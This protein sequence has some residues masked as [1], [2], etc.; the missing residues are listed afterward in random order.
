MNSEET[1]DPAIAEAMGC[2]DALSWLK[3]QNYSR[4]ILELD[5]QQ[6]VHALNGSNIDLSYFGV[7]IGDCKSIAKDLD[8]F[9]FSFVKHQRTKWL[10]P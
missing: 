9:S 5:A 8:E 1:M 6:V 4:V 2:R 10:I 7:L 3:N